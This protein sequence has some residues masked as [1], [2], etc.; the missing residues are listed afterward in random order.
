MP[1]DTPKISANTATFLYSLEA[2]KTIDEIRNPKKVQKDFAVIQREESPVGRTRS[3]TLVEEDMLKANVEQEAPS[4][5]GIKRKG[6]VSSNL[7]GLKTS[8]LNEH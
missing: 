3:D 2:N 4:T 8:T 6:S 1:K 7:S 5:K